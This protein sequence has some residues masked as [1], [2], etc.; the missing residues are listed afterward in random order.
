MASYD[1]QA[2]Q[3]KRRRALQ[4]AMMQRIMAPKENAGPWS[5]LSDIG[6]AL[7]LSKG[8]GRLDEQELALADEK[9]TAQ[10]NMLANILAQ[11][12]R[13]SMIE[14]GAASPFPQDLSLSAELGQALYPTKSPL[15]LS[16]GAQAYGDD[17]SLLAENPKERER[18]LTQVDRGDAIDMLDQDANVVRTL[19]KGRAPSERKLTQVDRGDVIDMLDE[20]GAVVKSLPKGRTPEQVAGAEKDTRTFETGLRDKFLTQAKTFVD[21]RDSFDRIQA[22]GKAESPAGDIAMIFSYMKMLDPASTVREG[23]FA[24]VAAAGSIPDRIRGLYNRALEGDRLP[25][26]IRNDLLKQ[27]K[28]LYGE[29]EKAL[30]KLESEFSRVAG[31]NKAD[32]SNVIMDFRT[33]NQ[34]AGTPQRR[35][36]RDKKTGEMAEFEQRDGKWVRVK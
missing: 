13:R 10:R 28:A 21:V 27:A 36:A 15:I 9:S 5:A 35:Q 7:L 24:T 25:Q 29:Q 16:E 6:S 18:K 26:P 3:I 2:E 30:G 14:A 11:P 12:D 4:D 23:E 1:T 32:P 20:S 19:P 31:Q 33:Q 22:A 34:D 8:G 17:M